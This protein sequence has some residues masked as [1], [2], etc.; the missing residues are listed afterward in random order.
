ME[1]LAQNVILKIGFSVLLML[2]GFSGIANEKLRYF[3][4]DETSEAYVFTKF[5][6][7]TKS[8]YGVDRKITLYNLMLNGYRRVNNQDYQ[9]VKFKEPPLILFS[10]LPDLDGNEDWK[11]INLDSIKDKMID[12][13]YLRHLFSA[14]TQDLPDQILRNE[15]KY[16]N[17]YQVIVKKGN[18]YLVSKNCLLQF[19]VISS[20]P[21]PFANVYCTI[22]IKQTPISI[23]NFE[24]IYKSV[25]PNDIFPLYTMGESDKL[26]TFQRS[27]DRR[28][29]L[30]KIFKIGESTAYQFWT[31]SDWQKDYRFYEVDRGIDRFVYLPGKGIVGGS[32][33]FYF[34]FNRKKLPIKYAD[35]MNN[36][37]EERVM[38]AENY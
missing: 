19:Y 35:F 7:S 15:T 37:K 36:I 13:R 6:L 8:L 32:F 29:Y 11:E 10:V 14:N 5:D 23:L 4:L 24:K 12:L 31:Y 21:E 27:R 20:R 9:Y 17:D 22:N 30:S 33:D 18:K 1:K 2:I 16:L 34:Y 3:L 25:Y 38:M 26:V 28:E